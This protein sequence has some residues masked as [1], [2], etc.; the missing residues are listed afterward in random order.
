MISSH[1]PA[2]LAPHPATRREQVQGVQ[3]VQVVLR[4]LPPPD[5]GTGR[6]DRACQY[7][8]AS[9]QYHLEGMFSLPVPSVAPVPPPASPDWHAAVS[10]FAESS[11]RRSSISKNPA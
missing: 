11:F 8:L 9:A 1:G 10:P 7:H 6:W 3:G 2:L 5:G 4:G